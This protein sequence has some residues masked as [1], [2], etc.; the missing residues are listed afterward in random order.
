[1]S[2][3]TSNQDFLVTSSEILPQS[4]EKKQFLKLHLD[5][6]T[7]IML[8]IEQITEVL[9]IPFGQ[10]IPIPQM[11]S[12][13]MGVYNWRGE[14]LWMID[15]GNLLGLKSWYEQEMTTANYTAVVLSTEQTGQVKANQIDK[16]NLGLVITKVDELEWCN[17]NKIQSP[18]ASVINSELEPFLQG[19]WLKEDGEM[20]AMINGKAIFAAVSPA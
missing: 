9:K 2:D 18:P 7:K 15:L 14:I 10:I 1:M 17:P 12:S 19:Y 16:V 5:P 6:N 3:L 11:S 20:I 4:A 13:V 8:P